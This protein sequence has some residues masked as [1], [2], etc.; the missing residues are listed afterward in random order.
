MEIK[1]YLPDFLK[2]VGERKVGYYDINLTEV[3]RSADHL[4]A[5]YE[6]RKDSLGRIELLTGQ[7]VCVGD[8]VGLDSAF[9]GFTLLRYNKTKEQEKNLVVSPAEKPSR[10]E[11]LTALAKRFNELRTKHDRGTI[12]TALKDDLDESELRKR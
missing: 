1:Q 12:L 2:P 11:V 5:D 10:D 4:L 3:E 8:L 6:R 7:R 9:A